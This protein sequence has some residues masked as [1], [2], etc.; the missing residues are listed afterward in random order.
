MIVDIVIRML[1]LLKGIVMSDT[2]KQ[3]IEDLVL[4][5]RH[6]H[7]IPMDGDDVDDWC[8]TIKV[9]LNSHEGNE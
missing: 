4:F 8:E 3:V 5:G 9:L 7:D 2:L 6:E 1:I